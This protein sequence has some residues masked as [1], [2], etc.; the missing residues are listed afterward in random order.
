MTL[1]TSGIGALPPKYTTLDHPEVEFESNNTLYSALP[2]IYNMQPESGIA[3]QISDLWK[4]FF[5]SLCSLLYDGITAFCPSSY[6][7]HL[8]IPAILVNCKVIHLY[9]T[10]ADLKAHQVNAFIPDLRESLWSEYRTIPSAPNDLFIFEDILSKTPLIGRKENDL[11]SDDIRMEKYKISLFRP[12]QPSQ[13]DTVTLHDVTESSRSIFDRYL[14]IKT[15]MALDESQFVIP[16]RFSYFATT[17][18]CHTYFSTP[19]FEQGNL[20]EFLDS[21][22]IKGERLA[23]SLT[24][25][26]LKIAMNQKVHYKTGWLQ[27]FVVEK[28]QDQFKVKLC[29]PSSIRTLSELKKFVDS[30]V[31]EGRK[32]LDDKLD[33]L[34]TN[35]TFILNTPDTNLPIYFLDLRHN[36]KTISQE[37]F[38]KNLLLLKDAINRQ[39]LLNMV[40]SVFIRLQSYEKLPEFLKPNPISYYRPL[41]KK[42]TSLLCELNERELTCDPDH[43]EQLRYSLS[44]EE[45]IEELAKIVEK[46]LLEMSK[47]ES[48]APDAKIP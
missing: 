26:L 4:E 19:Y 18:R 6:R 29:A 22:T 3:Q 46:K 39:N 36:W 25:D 27:D 10:A 40:Q 34:N 2:G 28:D 33:T 13:T 24:L 20:D 21:A 7:P 17:E 31:Q 44:K 15:S 9:E 11:E 38:I 35:P 5:I 47:S 23:L 1:S 30:L 42:Y 41:H 14:H 45:S 37:D 48:A 8:S 32:P 12:G 16:Q 43:A